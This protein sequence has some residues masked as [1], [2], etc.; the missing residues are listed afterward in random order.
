M[1]VTP[2]WNKWIWATLVLSLGAIIAIYLH[3]E[4][5]RT[6]LPVLHPTGDFHLTN[7]LG[8]VIGKESLM[9]HPTVV[10]V[11]FSRCPTQCHRLSQQMSRLQARIGPNIRL[12]SLSADPAY[13]TPE[14]LTRYGQKYAADVGHWWFLTGAKAEVYR[15]ATSDLLFTVLEN[16]DPSHAN[17][18]DLFIHSADFAILDDQA[19]LRAVVHGEE[20][21]AL[22]RIV[23]IL[24]QL[25]HER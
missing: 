22:N 11:I 10:N 4:F 6:P 7:Q 14:V 19:R 8:N 21:D 9:G 1:A 25:R 23:E 20:P 17:L 5:A 15:F 2:W 3:Q 12:L 13:D 24:D 16:P 18:E